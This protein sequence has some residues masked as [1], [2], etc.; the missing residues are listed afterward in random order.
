MIDFYKKAIEHK[1]LLINIR[2]DFHRSPELGFEE[3]ETSKKIKQ[4]LDNIGVEYESIAKTGIKAVIRGNGSKTVALRSDIDA[5]PIQE[6]NECSYKSEI[7]GRMH[8]CGHDV[9]MTV[10]L[11]AAKILKSMEKELSGNVVLLF[12]P[13]EETV[14]GA[15][16]MI[17]E[18]ALENPHVDAV[19]GLHVNENLECGTIGLKSGVIHAASNPF[20]VKITGKGAHGAHP[21]MGVD[22]IVISCNVINALQTL[23]SR[24]TSP[25]DSAALTIGAIHGGTAENIIPDEVEFKGTM[26]TLS[27]EHRQFMKMRFKEVVEGVSALM[28]GRAEI[29][30]VEGYPC[31]YND[32]RMLEFLR[33]IASTLLDQDKII[34]LQAPSLGVESFAY[35][36]IARPAVFYFLGCG[37][38]ENGIIHP[39]HNSLFDVD[40]DCLPLGAALQ[41]LLAYSFLNDK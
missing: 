11:G 27:K 4:F 18:G 26:R 8:A 23:V 1:D 35:F 16:Y 31:L 19:I 25:T 17:D 15:R 24:E 21:D 40:E 12:E 2:R 3:H 39:A 32:D 36:S 20:S 14:G 28:R 9:H 5:L 6:K 29:N 7:Q 13:A 10:L 41:A 38:K 22:P 33:K 37:N 34:D 30:M